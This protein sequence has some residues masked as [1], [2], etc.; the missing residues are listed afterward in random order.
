MNS[1]KSFLVKLTSHVLEGTIT[2]LSVLLA[3]GSLYWFE[4]GW[5]KFAGTVGFL[6]AGYVITYWIAKMRD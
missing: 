6:I 2:F 3:M 4:N 5:A 1:A